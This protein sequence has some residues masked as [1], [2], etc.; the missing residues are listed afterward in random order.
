MV[1]PSLMG[2]VALCQMNIAMISDEHFWGLC[3]SHIEVP[4]G[5]PEPRIIECP[6]A[7]VDEDEE[8]TSTDFRRWYQETQEVAHPH[9]ADGEVEQEFRLCN[10]LL[11]WDPSAPPSQDMIAAVQGLRNQESQSHLGLRCLLRQTVVEQLV[12]E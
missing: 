2:I 3:H 10:C 5:P 4:L 7:D 8:E 9:M 1:G 12:Y 6:I 11:T